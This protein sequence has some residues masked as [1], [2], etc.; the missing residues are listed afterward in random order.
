MK[1]G[2]TSG[3]KLRKV[4]GKEA[5]KEKPGK[6]E[7]NEKEG[8]AKPSKFMPFPGSYI[9]QRIWA[10]LVLLLATLVIVYFTPKQDKTIYLARVKDSVDNRRLD[11]KCSEDY[12]KEIIEYGG[13][14]P[15]K[16]GRVVMD[17]L[18]TK[19]E[20]E[21]LIDIAKRGLALGGSDG[22]ASILD[23]HSGALSKGKNFINIFSFPNITDIFRINDFAL[24]IRVRRKIQEAVAYSFKI[25]SDKLYLTKPTFFS[26]LTSIEPAT[27]HDEYW[28]LHV[29][30]NVYQ[31][32][33]YTSLVYLND[34]NSDFEGG[35]FV[36]EDPENALTIVEPKR[37]RVSAFTSGEENA[38][39]VERVTSGTRYAV[40][41]S[42]TCDKKHAIGDPNFKP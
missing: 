42:F 14:V 37:G 38:H 24:Y 18:L 30:K 19:E 21:T 27:I 34:Y 4:K 40:T 16:C 39:R 9:K 23:L 22:G 17:K 35:R 10:R 1:N 26:R 32:F 3:V 2:S 25:D 13:C 41:I 29:D 33:H 11:V 31:S 7:T 20:T 12:F 28:H 5:P 36:F 15:V 6:A 8:D